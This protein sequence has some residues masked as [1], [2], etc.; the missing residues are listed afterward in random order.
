MVPFQAHYMQNGN[1]SRCYRCHW[2]TRML[3]VKKMFI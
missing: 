2:S 1:K 3:Y